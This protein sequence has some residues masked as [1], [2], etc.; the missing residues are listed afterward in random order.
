MIGNYLKIAWRNLRSNKEVFLI[1]ILGLA[2]GIASFLI[3]MLFV[4]DE[5]SYD[6]HHEKADNIARIVTRG[7]IGD[8]IINQAHTQAPIASVLKREF[9]EVKNSARLRK[10]KATKIA[11]GNN[12]FRDGEVAMV[13][14]AFLEIFTIPFV[15]GNAATALSEPNSIVIDEEQAKKYF[16][17]QDPLNKI[18]NYGDSKQ[19]FKVTGVFKK[20]PRNSHFHFD[21]FIT[22]T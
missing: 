9:P 1:N 15:K 2:I 3:L 18:V 8:N 13:D 4:V 14:P 5:L 7:R 19:S 6:Q 10:L 17:D 11:Y 12:T 21:H 20:I 22:T 16:G